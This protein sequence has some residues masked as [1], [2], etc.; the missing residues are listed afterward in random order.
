MTSSCTDHLSARY[1]RLQERYG[2]DR[3]TLRPIPKDIHMYWAGMQPSDSA[4]ANMRAWV[5]KARDAGWRLHL[6][7]DNGFTAW[8]PDVQR[9]LSTDL[10]AHQ[11]TAEVLAGNLGPTIMRTYHAVKNAGAHNFGSNIARYA[12]LGL[13]PHSLVH[14]S[15]GVYVDVD[16]HPG[17]V[18]LSQVDAVTMRHDDVPVFAPRL[19]DGN[20]VDQILRDA[21]EDG[22]VTDPDARIRRAAELMYERGGLNNNVI[23]APAR[24]EFLRRMLDEIPDRYERFVASVHAMYPGADPEVLAPVLAAMLKQSSPQ[25]GG[26]DMIQGSYYTEPGAPDFMSAYARDV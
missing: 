7:T 18:D 15:G 13:V 25:I 5:D 19:R 3:P 10:V 14:E 26:P 16:I 24:S 12:V 11:D 17:D 6:W 20:S 9:V 2:G 1:A 23:V 4:L 21:G 8:D 22:D